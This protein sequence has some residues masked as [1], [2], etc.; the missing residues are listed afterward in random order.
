MGFNHDPSHTG[1]NLCYSR[2]EHLQSPKY[3]IMVRRRNISKAKPA[4]NKTVPKSKSAR[5]KATRLARATEPKL[6]VQYISKEETPNLL[7]PIDGP[8]L[9]P[10]QFK[11]PESSIKWI[12]RIDAKEQG[13]GDVGSY[14]Y[15]AEIDGK[16][17]AI[18]VV[19][20]QYHPFFISS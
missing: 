16:I 15:R 17:Y 9:Y 7:P 10:F 12:E 19:R 1:A 11:S 13:G 6:P 3:T 14:I 4:Q 20:A 2:T 8:A 18:K 5:T